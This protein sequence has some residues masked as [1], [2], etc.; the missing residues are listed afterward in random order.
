MAGDAT[1][2]AGEAK[3]LLLLEHPHDASETAI[4]AGWAFSVNV[5]V[6]RG[7]NEIKNG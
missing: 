4:S 7:P 3:A 2:L 1:D 5:R 6:S